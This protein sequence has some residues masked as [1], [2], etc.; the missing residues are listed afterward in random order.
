MGKKWYINCIFEKLENKRV[1]IKQQIS[2]QF[3]QAKIGQNS[4]DESQNND[5]NSK[6]CPDENN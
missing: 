4:L 1:P 3:K 2:I 6:E 5:Q